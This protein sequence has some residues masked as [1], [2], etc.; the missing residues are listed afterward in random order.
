[1][2]DDAKALAQKVGRWMCDIPFARTLGIEFT[3]ADVGYG[4]ARMVVSKE[5]LN[6]VGIIHGGAVFAFADT[7]FGVACNS[8][9][10]VAVAL[11][12]S[13]TFSAPSY[14]GEVLICEAKQLSRSRKTGHY[15]VNVHKEDGTHVAHY[16][17]T[18]YMR[19]DHVDHWMEPKSSEPL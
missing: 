17:G 3:D 7:I 1:M 11:S 8:E 13:I 9:G 16:S 12:C 2:S 10:Q 18:A 4:L 15:D 5:M 6:G 14:E 19:S